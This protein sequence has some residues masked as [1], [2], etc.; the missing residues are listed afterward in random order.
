MPDARTV[1][2][3]RWSEPTL[4]L[5]SP[6]WFAAEEYPWSCHRDGLA[7]PVEDATACRT[8]GRWEARA[9]EDRRKSGRLVRF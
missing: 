5:V 7:R 6:L 2:Q 9:S 4:F 3:C 8:C 1:Q